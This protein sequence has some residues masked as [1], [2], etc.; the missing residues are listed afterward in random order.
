[1]YNGKNIM[2]DDGLT[3]DGLG[4]LTIH[5]N[6]NAKIRKVFGSSDVIK[7]YLT[8]YLQNKIQ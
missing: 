8:P 5:I 6:I 4:S 7:T 3:L 2:V 1:M